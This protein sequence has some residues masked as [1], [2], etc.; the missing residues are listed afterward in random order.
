MEND[1]VHDVVKS[2]YAEVARQGGGCCGSAPSSAHAKTAALI[3]YA[4]DDITGA[5][6]RALRPM[7]ISGLAV[8]TRRRWRA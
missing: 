8:A 3:G 1:Q 5:T 6:S 2:G 4:E 7:P